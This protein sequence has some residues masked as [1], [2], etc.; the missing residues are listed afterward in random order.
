MIDCN[1]SNC[2]SMSVRCGMRRRRGDASPDAFLFPFTS[3]PL[4][5]FFLRRRVPEART[6]WRAP[7]R[8][9]RAWRWAGDTP[10]TPRWPC[11]LPY[12]PCQMCLAC[13]LGGL[14]PPCVC[15]VSKFYAIDTGSAGSWGRTLGLPVYPPPLLSRCLCRST[16]TLL[17]APVYIRETRVSWLSPRP[18]TWGPPSPG[19]DRTACGLDTP[20]NFR[21]SATW[22]FRF[23]EFLFS[24]RI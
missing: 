21:L 1:S 11:L 24:K 14:Q 19:R 18:R 10:G 16:L 22:P 12:A 15:C 9:A 2:N 4:V 8:A 6:R 3:P 13:R 23:Q 5:P 17:G 7:Q 20:T